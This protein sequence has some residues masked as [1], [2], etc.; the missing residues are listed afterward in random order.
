MSANS[1]TKDERLHGKSSVTAL[2]QEGRWGMTGP[3]LKYC[4]CP[5]PESEFS[6]VVISVPKRLF[7]R[8]VRRN[9]LKRRIREAF[10]TRK[11]LLGESP[12]DILFQYN[13]SEIADYAAI[14]DEVSLILQRIS[15]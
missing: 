1:F 10:R 5:R 14:R 3:L 9:L 8:A 7:K 4:W 13:S 15:R 2:L 11:S 12:C 6:R